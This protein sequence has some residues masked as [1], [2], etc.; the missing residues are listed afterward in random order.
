MLFR[1]QRRRNTLATAYPQA[2]LKASDAR[3]SLAWGGNV[4]LNEPCVNHFG[5]TIPIFL[6]YNTCLVTACHISTVIHHPGPCGSQNFSKRSKSRTADNAHDYDGTSLLSLLS[7][8][9]LISILNTSGHQYIFQ[10]PESQKQF[11]EG[12]PAHCVPSKTQNWHNS[13]FRPNSLRN[14]ETR[15]RWPARHLE[16]AY[17]FDDIGAY[18]QL[19]MHISFPHIYFLYCYMQVYMVHMYVYIY[20]YIYTYIYLVHIHIHIHVHVHIHIHLHIQ[21][22][23]HIHIIAYTYTSTYGNMYTYIC[24]RVCVYIH[25]SNDSR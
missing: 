21:V 20:I 9:P 4:A 24:I 10:L 15:S 25:R 2:L 13:D 12:V 7:P 19:C 16:R 6:T 5:A 14:S 11:L 8:W 23:I 22:Q 3:C 18:I 1:P 17:I